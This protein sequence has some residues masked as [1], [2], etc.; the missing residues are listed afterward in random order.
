MSIS[1]YEIVMCIGACGSRV[2]PRSR[3]C[4]VG[5]VCFFDLFVY[6]FICGL[7]LVIFVLFDVHVV[8]LD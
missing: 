7:V 5:V 3:M 8:M 6:V 4:G 1:V 2:C